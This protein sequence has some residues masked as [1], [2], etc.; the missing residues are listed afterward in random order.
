MNHRQMKSESLFD[1][2]KRI[3]FDREE[4]EE[5]V[6]EFLDVAKLYGFGG[7]LHLL[8]RTKEM[9]SA[10]AIQQQQQQQQQ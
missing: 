7:D 1:Y 10:L 8:Q 4:E 6:L 9:D 2:A 3:G 5:E